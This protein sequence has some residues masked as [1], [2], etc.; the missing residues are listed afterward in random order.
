MATS[1]LPVVMPIPLAD[2]AALVEP[3]PT[4]EE[5]F[6]NSLD[7]EYSFA[8]GWDLGDYDSAPS[9]PPSKTSPTL[10]EQ[11]HSSLPT[12]QVAS[13]Q[14]SKRTYSVAEMMALRSRPEC[15]RPPQ[16]P[17]LQEVCSSACKDGG[18]FITVCRN[19]RPARTARVIGKKTTKAMKDRS[20]QRSGAEQRI[21]KKV[22]KTHTNEPKKLEMSRKI[23]KMR[24]VSKKLETSIMKTYG[25]FLV[26]TIGSTGQSCA[27]RVDAPA[28]TLTG[29]VAEPRTIDS[30]TT[31]S[32][33]HSKQGPTCVLRID[34]PAFVIAQPPFEPNL[35]PIS[36]KMKA[37]KILHNKKKRERKTRNKRLATQQQCRTEAYKAATNRLQHILNACGHGPA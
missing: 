33:S 16:T 22:T 11:D 23:E 27:L 14:H 18:G 13:T 19:G 7:S 12:S 8:D 17:L 20:N 15:I 32:A 25:T 28:F 36:Q 6:A 10:G 34:A 30:D 26:A 4:E 35:E 2:R 37:R 3:E 24:D 5:T 21:A 1:M 9:L 29:P 31:S